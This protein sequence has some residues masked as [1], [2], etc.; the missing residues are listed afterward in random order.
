[1]YV[2]LND[3]A[4]SATVQSLLKQYDLLSHKLVFVWAD[5]VTDA[6]KTWDLLLKSASK[7]KTCGLDIAYVFYGDADWPCTKQNLTQECPPCINLKCQEEDLIRLKGDLDLNAEIYLGSFELT[8][9]SK[10]S[11]VQ[12]QH[13]KDRDADNEHLSTDTTLDSFDII[14]WEWELCDSLNPVHS[15]T[16]IT[17]NS[18]EWFL[19]LASSSQRLPMAIILDTYSEDDEVDGFAEKYFAHSMFL[20]QSWFSSSSS[21]DS[22]NLTL[23]ASLS[24]DTLCLKFL[25]QIGDA[26]NRE[27]LYQKQIEESPIVSHLGTLSSAP[28]TFLDP[29]DTIRKVEC[30]KSYTVIKYSPDSVSI[31]PLVVNELPKFSQILQFTTN[32][33]QDNRTLNF[34]EQICEIV[35]W[36][37]CQGDE[38][39]TQPLYVIFDPMSLLI[40]NKTQAKP[41]NESWDFDSRKGNCIVVGC[42][43]QLAT[44]LKNWNATKNFCGEIPVSDQ[45]VCVNSYI[46]L[47]GDV[48]DKSKRDFKKGVY[49]SLKE[50]F[51]KH[52]V[53]HVTELTT[54]DAQAMT[55]S[56]TTIASSGQ[57]QGESSVSND[58]DPNVIKVSIKEKAVGTNNNIGDGKGVSE[59]KTFEL[60]ISGEED[61]LCQFSHY[62]SQSLPLVNGVLHL[63]STKSDQTEIN[64]EA[65]QLE[66][67]FNDMT[68]T[69][70]L[71]LSKLALSLITWDS[72][73][74]TDNDSD[75]RVKAVLA[76][77]L[78]ELRDTYPDITDKTYKGLLGQMIEYNQYHDEEFRHSEVNSVI[79]A[80]LSKV[81]ECLTDVEFVDLD[82]DI[83][84]DLFFLYLRRGNV[85]VIEAFIPHIP[86]TKFIAFNL[87]AVGVYK[88][89]LKVRSDLSGPVKEG[90]QK[91]AK[92]LESKAKSV[93][94]HIYAHNSALSEAVLF[95]ESKR[96]DNKSA[97]DLACIAEARH[98]L[99]DEAC[100]SAINTSWWQ[101]LSPTPWYQILL[102][103]ALPCMIYNSNMK[104]KHKSENVD[105]DRCSWRCVYRSP[106]IRC[107]VHYVVF[108]GFL[109]FYSYVL[110]T[111]LSDGID[112]HEYI[113][114]VWMGSLFTEEVRQLILSSSGKN[115][116]FAKYFKEFWNILDVIGLVLFSIGVILSI[117][118]SVF[119]IRLMLVFAHAVF[120]IHVILLYVRSLQ[121]FAMHKTIGPLL[122]MIQGMFK[123]LANFV[124]ILLVVLVGY[125]VALHAVLHPETE[126]NFGM[127]NGIFHIPY[128]QLYG[129]VGV[130]YE[131]EAGVN[132]TYESDPSEL[133]LDVRNY[134]GLY[135]AGFY[136]L[137]TNILLLNLLIAMFNTTYIKIEEKTG[138]YDVI[139]KISVL[140]EYQECFN[141]PPPFVVISYAIWGFTKCCSLLEKTRKAVRPTTPDPFN[142]DDEYFYYY[143]TTIIEEAIKSIC[144]KQ[145]EFNIENVHS[146]I[147]EIK[148]LIRDEN[149]HLAG[150]VSKQ[151]ELIGEL[152]EKK[153]RKRQ[154]KKE[155][156]KSKINQEVKS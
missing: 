55:N 150:H 146:Q 117:I 102:F 129:E 24:D 124:L 33:S 103:L 67:S 13:T 50:A 85:T 19:S 6:D 115:G 79:S 2:V 95:E 105:D 125:A 153:E 128:F 151:N 12:D 76:K 111:G 156:S 121:F 41:I 123:D 100:M 116:N 139:H 30:S 14:E 8:L 133:E 126:V 53:V 135:L 107:R 49:D 96:F 140:Q 69:E 147:K 119:G 93:I 39:L 110:L 109:L 122:I 9:K 4:T 60:T 63:V 94:H 26:N 15:L 23:L 31:P 70:P 81:S 155:K 83:L 112:I 21:S 1:M 132:K 37:R 120:A 22:V 114:L 42:F 35:E 45:N 78:V 87:Y 5:S 149:K 137:V 56:A 40:N 11:L 84:L 54:D 144:A 20:Y 138:F 48:L 152:L 68:T 82:H 130:E 71:L 127:I 52:K 80:K 10:D 145:T 98:F 77:V 44:S 64:C 118:S 65:K 131:I 97:F 136:L 75:M 36:L 101:C 29:W 90:L 154:K 99:S 57:S 62:S 88:N 142:D 66:S 141:L 86:A 47:D 106:A 74:D 59:S 108:M 89:S 46:F 73:D 134:I 61:D 51:L 27:N 148:Q 28:L 72:E 92:T 17:K 3:T 18:L 143:D 7:A 16:V 38:E 32:R 58:S 91:S 104:V 34:D 43:A 113:I 25:R